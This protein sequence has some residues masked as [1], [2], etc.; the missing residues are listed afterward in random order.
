MKPDYEG[1]QFE[2]WVASSAGR[3]GRVVLGMTIA[4]AALTLLPKPLNVAVA[5][6]GLIPIATGV[7]NLCPIAPV[8]G[9]HFRGSRYCQRRQ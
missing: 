7:L 9:G 8:W 5:A 1:T 3:F 4:A 6:L 2:H